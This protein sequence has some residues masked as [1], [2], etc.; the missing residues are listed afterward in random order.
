MV[1]TQ[2]FVYLTAADGRTRRFIQRSGAHRSVTVPLQ[3]ARPACRPRRPSSL[4]WR[5]RLQTAPTPTE[6]GDGGAGRAREQVSESVKRLYDAYPFPPDPLLDGP[7]PGYNWRW[8]YPTAYAFCARGRLPPTET[9]RILDAGCGTGC[10]TE[11]LVHLNPQAQVVGFDLSPAAVEVAR[12]R[13]SRSVPEALSRVQLCVKSIY[14][15]DVGEQ[16][17]GHFDMINCVGVVHH[18]SDPAAALQ[19]LARKLALGGILHL[20]V[21]AEAGRWEIRRM[22]QAIALLQQAAGTRGDVRDG[23]Q[24]GRALFS[25]L[26]ENNRL[27][28]R[29]VERWASDNRHDATFADMYVHPQEHDYDV[30]SVLELARRSGLRFLGWSNPR[31]FDLSRLLG[32]DPTVMQRAAL[33]D[34][35]SRWR[36]VELLDPEQVTHF[37]FFLAKEPFPSEPLSDQQLLRAMPEL[38]QC[39]HGFPSLSLLDRDYHPVNIDE[40]QLEFGKAMA[41]DAQRQEASRATVEQLLQRSRCSLAQVRSLLD[42]GIVHVRAPE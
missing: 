37:E 24:L 31:Q 29:E 41:A 6:S 25:A 42:Q 22:Q 20:F 34:D 23:V 8:H 35:I 15:L 18:T 14:D 11:Y 13:L 12:Q 16:V 21:Y 26:P 10:G 7:P 27:R 28:R 3:T 30:H 9:I 36:L 38:S 39:V 19:C 1:E 32:S 17:A 33:L 40:A 2:G 5:L 4:L